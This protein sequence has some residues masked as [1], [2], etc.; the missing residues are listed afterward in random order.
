[1][2]QSFPAKRC[3]LFNVAPLALKLRNDRKAHTD[4]LRH[5]Q[6]ETAT[7]REIVKNERL[8]NPLNTSLDYACLSVT[9]M[10]QAGWLTGMV[11]LCKYPL[12]LKLERDFSHGDQMKLPELRDR[13]ILRHRKFVRRSSTEIVIDFQLRGTYDPYR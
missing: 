10:G 12:S 5:T 4:Y 2:N 8:L 13:D 11:V 7:L 1:M 3:R 6:E 9:H